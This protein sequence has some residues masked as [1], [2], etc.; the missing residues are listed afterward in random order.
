M[1]KYEMVS[2]GWATKNRFGL[3]RVGKYRTAIGKKRNAEKPS[4][5]R[6]L[7]PLVA[8]DEEQA[9]GTGRQ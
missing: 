5:I 6:A 3:V 2:P 1:D 8:A 7:A 4:Y 9:T